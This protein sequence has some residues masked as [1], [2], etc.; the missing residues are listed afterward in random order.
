LSIASSVSM[1]NPAPVLTGGCEPNA[2]MTRSYR[3]ITPRVAASAYVDQSAQLI[4]DVS[5]GAKS[6]VWP[7]AVLRGDSALIEVGEETNIQD[8]CIL[9]TDEG[10]IL[11]VGNR[12]TVGHGV[13]LHGCVLEDECLIGIGATVLNHARVGRGAVIGAGA[14]IP[15]GMEVPAGMIA[16]GV[17]A[18][19]RREVTAEERE[20]FR[21]GVE[22]YVERAEIYRG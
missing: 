18:K 8:G 6:S 15:E 20:R 13:M 7:C 3:G 1:K 19:V 9:H 21:A 11:K 12:V 14:L 10:I 22:H 16:L 2:I 5:V 4:G 17:P